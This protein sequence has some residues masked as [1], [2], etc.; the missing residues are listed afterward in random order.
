MKQ[1]V[2]SFERCIQS[3]GSGLRARAQLCDQLI[4][5]IQTKARWGLIG[6]V[7]NIMTALS[8]RDFRDSIPGSFNTTSSLAPH[9]PNAGA[10]LN[11]L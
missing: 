9:L 11:L 10:S 6:V 4:T 7:P 5:A 2:T 1:G 3:S 8:A